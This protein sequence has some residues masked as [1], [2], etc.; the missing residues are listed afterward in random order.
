MVST[1]K[2]KICGEFLE[3]TKEH[4]PPKSALNKGKIKLLDP[5][6]TTKL[7]TRDKLPWEQDDLKYTIRQNGMHLQ[8][9]C[10]KCNNLTGRNY[11]SAYKDFVL[12]I[13]HIIQE[14]KITTGIGLIIEYDKFNHLPVFKQ[15]VSMF[16]SLSN[17]SSRHT[18][19]KDFLLNPEIN[20]FP[21]SDIHIFINIYLDGQDGLFG[22]IA[23]S[24]SGSTLLTYQIK[25]YP[26]II[27]MVYDYE[28]SKHIGFDFGYDITHF[29]EYKYGDWEPQRFLLKAIESHTF[30]PTENRSKEQI[31][32]SW[33]YDNEE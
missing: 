1:G 20:D 2:C 31:L 32:R 14:K 30:V 12:S 19:I 8:T 15:I 26:L 5:S 29:H 9:L 27:T 10:K 18:I 11:G 13:A 23:S 4:I 7:L 17:L 25:R 21:S 16:A 22:P 24:I 33:N 28:K 3:L 6:E